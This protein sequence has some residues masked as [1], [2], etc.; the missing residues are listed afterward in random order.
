LSEK[1]EQNASA[2]DPGATVVKVVA[3]AATTVCGGALLYRGAWLAAAR[4][5]SIY[6]IVVSFLYGT[7]TEGGT[8][9][10]GIA[11]AGVSAG[12][13]VARGV[14]GKR[15]FGAASDAVRNDCGQWSLVRFFR[16][17]GKKMSLEDVKKLVGRE[18]LTHFADLVLA[19]FDTLGKESQVR[20]GLSRSAV[21][22]LIKKLV[23]Q[24]RTNSFIIGG[25]K[26][27]AQVGHFVSGRRIGKHIRLTDLQGRSCANDF[28]KEFDEFVIIFVP[29]KPK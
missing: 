22:K 11:T 27:G 7:V 23:G 28:F 16:N 18:G 10:G 5:P 19:I 4:L 13:R 24:G 15:L 21:R 8:I 1:L 6:D 12:G 2:G 26:G 20:H 3:V 29:G 17:R 9:A 14:T 25:S